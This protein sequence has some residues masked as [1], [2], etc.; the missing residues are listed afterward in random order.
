LE[1][2]HYKPEPKGKQFNMKENSDLIQDFARRRYQSNISLNQDLD[3]DET[4]SR[5]TIFDTVLW[6]TIISDIRVK[7]HADM[8]SITLLLQNDVNGLEILKHSKDP[9][10]S[11]YWISAPYIPNTVLVNTG[12]HKYLYSS[13]NNISIKEIAWRC[14]LIKY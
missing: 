6:L 11:P 12:I 13:S 5:Y 10:S 14:G 7:S 2:K 4:V 8:S 9:L 3:N 1:L